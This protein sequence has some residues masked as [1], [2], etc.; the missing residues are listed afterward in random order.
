ML[1]EQRVR[2][3]EMSDLTCLDAGRNLNLTSD[4]MAD[5]W[6]QGIAAGDGNDPAPNPTPPLPQK[7]P[8]LKLE[9]RYSWIPEGIICPRRSNIIQN[10][11]NDF[12]NYSRDK[13][14][15]MKKLEL[16]LILFP[17]ENLKEILSPEK[18]KTLKHPMDLRE[19]IWWLG[20]WF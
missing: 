15:K 13:V 17:V 3:V 16:F 5:L 1:L 2:G 11:Y 7:T 4:D 12:N 18:N 10:A 19:F 20:C 6:R 14:M 9:E 8:L